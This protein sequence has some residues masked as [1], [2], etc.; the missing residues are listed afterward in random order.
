MNTKTPTQLVRE[1]FTHLNRFELAAS[2]PQYD[3]PGELN[4]RRLALIMLY[5]DALENG[6]GHKIWIRKK[7]KRSTK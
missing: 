3:F 6:A 2:F 5:E 7:R 1:F 4:K